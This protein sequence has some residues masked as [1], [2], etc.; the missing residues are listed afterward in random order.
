MVI[1]QTG[2]KSRLG[3]MG[4]LVCLLGAWFFMVV[5]HFVCA[6]VVS[7]VAQCFDVS[8]VIQTQR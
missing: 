6:D 5:S 2:D 8:V 1:F 7:S 3:L 4:I